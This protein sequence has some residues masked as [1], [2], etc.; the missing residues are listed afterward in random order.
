M[1]RLRAFLFAVWFVGALV[2]LGLVCLPLLLFPRRAAV[3]AVRLWSRTILLG[4]RFI[5]GIRWEVRGL[6]H[7]PQGSILVAA[8]HQ[9]TLDTIA[10]FAILPDPCFALKSE[11]LKLPF[12][13]WFAARAGMI[14]IDRGGHSTALRALVRR[15]KARMAEPAQLVIFPE[16]TR[17][18]VGATPAYKPGVAG[19]YRELDIPCVP[20]ATNSGQV[21]GGKGFKLRPGL[22]V[23]EILPPIPPGL[24]RAA[25]MA[26]IETRIEEASRRLL[27][28]NPERP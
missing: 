13:G 11:L 10:P 7:L 16:G 15:A 27:E 25:F 26:E 6:E 22:A 12:Y 20:M 9:S 4:L 21:W 8:K 19:L 3:A 17:Q 1:L 23:F 2:V 5:C 24:K 18:A 28:A 14:P